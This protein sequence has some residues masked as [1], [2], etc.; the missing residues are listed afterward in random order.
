MLSNKWLRTGNKSVIQQQTPMRNVV[1]L[2]VEACRSIV[3]R[4]TTPM[5]VVN[6]VMAYR[7]SYLITSTVASISNKMPAMFGIR[8]SASHGMYSG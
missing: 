7:Y 5:R 1:A 2:L 4:T 6:F 8:D 3:V